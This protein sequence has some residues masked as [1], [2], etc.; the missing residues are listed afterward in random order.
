MVRVLRQLSLIRVVST[1]VTLLALARTLVAQGPV[2]AERLGYPRDAKLLILHADDLGVAHSVDR[3]SFVALETQA[4]SS[5]SVMVPCPWLSEVAEYFKQ[6]P[7]IDLGLHLTLTSEW[8]TYRWRPAAP[9]NQVESLLGE[10]G[11]LWTEDLSFS[12]HAKPEEVEREIRSQVVRAL[13]FGIHPTHL[14][15]HMGT[16]F[17]DPRYFA[18]LV[19]VAHEYGLPFLA[20]RDMSQKEALL[21]MLSP[22][23]LVLDS[24]PQ[25]RLRPPVP[26]QPDDAKQQY[27]AALRALSPGL[28]EII[29]HLGYDDAELQAIMVDH[30]DFGSAWRQ[31]DF[32]IVNSPEFKR[33]LAD[34]NITLITWRQLGRLLQ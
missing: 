9:W 12:Q 29:V 26:G 16:L 6:Q 21:P 34:N 11:Y 27:L 20:A 3:A 8:K 17:L 4:V 30:P 31:R 7:K 5:A 22:K 10:D 1:L 14:D 28:H 32:E 19:K 24:R 2:V 13:A 23:D 15:S 25:L 18:V 33:A